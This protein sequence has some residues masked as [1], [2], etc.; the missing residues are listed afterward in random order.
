[1]KSTNM[2]VQQSPLMTGPLGDGQANLQP[3]IILACQV[4]PR[5]NFLHRSEWLLMWALLTDALHVLAAYHPGKKRRNAKER[6]QW[7]A[8]RTWVRDVS[9]APFS[10]V[11]V[12]DHLGLDRDALRTH[13]E[14]LIAGEEVPGQSQ[15]Q[16]D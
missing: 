6:R 10:F 9:E 11:Y 14:R 3:D 8:D 1:M 7:E 16:L 4:R 15:L 5:N 12:C 13:V 2:A